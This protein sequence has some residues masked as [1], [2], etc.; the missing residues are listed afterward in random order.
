MKVEFS[1]K[2]LTKFGNIKWYYR[3]TGNTNFW[4]LII[5]WYGKFRIILFSSL[6]FSTSSKKFRWTHILILGSEKKIWRHIKLLFL[7]PTKNRY[8]GDLSWNNN[9]NF[10]SNLKEINVHL[11]RVSHNI[12]S[13]LHFSTA[14]SQPKWQ[15]Q[16]INREVL[17]SLEWKVLQFVKRL[18]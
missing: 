14:K 16:A 11:A 7:P 8:H 4:H 18:V 13:F 17:N 1:I 5:S 12:I 10:L 3:Y 15:T 9:L 2:H 6:Y